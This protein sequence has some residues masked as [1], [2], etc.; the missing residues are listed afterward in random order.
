[1]TTEEAISLVRGLIFRPG[2]TLEAERAPSYGP[3][4]IYVTATEQTVD[5]NREYAPEYR[6]AKEIADLDVIDV[7]FLTE[8][9]LMYRLLQWFGRMHEHE[10]REFLRRGDRNY[11]A[12][13]HPHRPEGERRWEVAKAEAGLA[14]VLEGIRS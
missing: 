11:E 3:G 2:W 5:T 6:K 1:V 13:F 14:E 10:D 4:H 9:G 7:R 8:D 12:P